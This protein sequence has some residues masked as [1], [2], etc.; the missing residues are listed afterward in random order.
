[1]TTARCR[2]PSA[3]SG[4]RRAERALGGRRCGRSPRS[5]KSATAARPGWR[6]SSTPPGSEAQA[7]SVRGSPRVHGGGSKN[8]RARRGF[9]DSSLSHSGR[10]WSG[11]TAAAEDPQRRG[12]R[13]PNVAARRGDEPPRRPATETAPQGRDLLPTCCP[14]LARSGWKRMDGWLGGTD[15]GAV[16]GKLL[17]PSCGEPRRENPDEAFRI[18]GSARPA[19]VRHE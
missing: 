2:H 19:N 5:E 11:C 7:A 6:T 1:M 13:G 4:R 3:S 14:S 9:I 10:F 16:V 8:H 15:V 17:T 18:G 12:R